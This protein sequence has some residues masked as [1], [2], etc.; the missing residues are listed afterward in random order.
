M[1]EEPKKSRPDL[2]RRGSKVSAG[3]RALVLE[4]VS[5][6]VADGCG[7]GKACAAI[8]MSERRLQR[9]I[10]SNGQEDQ[11]R[12]PATTPANKLSPSERE[13]IVA[14]A[15]SK[16]YR[17]MSPHQIVPKLADR[18]RYLASESSFYRILRASALLAHRGRSKPKSVTRPR[19]HE[20]LG[21]RQLFSWDSTYLRSE[22]KGRY[23]YLYLFLDVFS[24]KAV[25]WAVHDEESTEHASSLLMTVCR[26]EGIEKGRVR[27]HSDNGSPMKGATMLVTMQRLGVMPSFSRPSVSND[28]P[29]SESLFKTMKYCP[30]FP[31]MPFAS[32]EDARR[33]VAEFI[34]WYNNV[35]LHSA[36]RFTTPAAL[37]SG[38]DEAILAGLAAVY[39]DA[40]Q[41]NPSR[42]SGRTRN[43][44]KIDVVRL[45]WLKEDSASSTTAEIRYI[46]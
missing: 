21:P 5:S 17:D 24:R 33:W 22:A 34:H 35:H 45:N 46:S 16:E 1:S 20:A 31:S 15:N 3:N 9:W 25:G 36:I 39:R 19:G 37:H 30:Q 43:W 28:N 4:L 29:F 23:Y 26:E 32:I 40:K 38:E 7:Q 11:R 42:W 6:S 41:T 12:G 27:L 13:R 18:G 8:G 14:V 2:G 10:L 44:E